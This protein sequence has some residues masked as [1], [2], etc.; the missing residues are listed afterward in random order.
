MARKIS[1]SILATVVVLVYWKSVAPSTPND[2]SEVNYADFPLIFFSWFSQPKI[3]LK[4]VKFTSGLH[5]A[6]HRD[7][8]S[9]LL[10]VSSRTLLLLL[11]TCFSYFSSFLV[12]SP[13]S[14]G[15]WHE[16]KY[17]QSKMTVINEPCAQFI[18]FIFL[19]R[20]FVKCWAK[21]K[22][23]TVGII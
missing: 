22:K 5:W 9:V 10:P 14:C 1:S 4:K 17:R 20:L 16:A 21:Q 19:F 7:E 8:K 15:L 3:L 18:I 6:P 12:W 13:Y 11:D 2:P 23:C